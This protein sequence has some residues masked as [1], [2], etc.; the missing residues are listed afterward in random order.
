MSHQE[1]INAQA[2]SVIREYEKPYKLGRFTGIMPNDLKSKSIVV[3]ATESCAMVWSIVARQR[4]VKDFTG[5]I[6]ARIEP[7]EILITRCAVLPD[8]SLR[9]RASLN[10]GSW[11]HEIETRTAAE[12]I[13]CCIWQE[14]AWMRWYLHQR[15]FQFVGLQVTACSEYRA[16][17]CKGPGTF[18][19]AD[20][21]D[22]ASLTSLNMP[23]P[24]I[25]VAPLLAAIER[26]APQFAPH[27]SAYNKR[28]SWSAVAL[29][30]F[31][32]TLFDIEKP[33]EM[34][35]AWKLEHA[36]HLKYECLDTILRAAL[37]EVE[38]ILEA[39]GGQPFQR[40]RLMKL[41]HGQGELSRHADITDKEAGTA[42]GKIMRLH[43]PIV[44][45]PA[46]EF[47]SW[48]IFGVPRVNHFE[49][50]QAFYLDTRKAHKA[51]NGGPNDRIHL[52]VD[53]IANADR[54]ALISYST[55]G[56]D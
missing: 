16:L 50:G 25:D 48:D 34:S 11:L 8:E 36:E 3:K 32:G 18:R 9:H 56:G 55:K 13:W 38:P 22:Y 1:E 39:L 29:R 7:G 52:V 6:C 4:H 47:T 14:D 19:K 23:E 28:K 45:N 41:S 37:P 51:I 2:Y 42:D 46:V 5:E 15:G 17:Y 35:K 44:T 54:R 49:Q 40:I 33:A 53:C 12:T 10:V 43:V 27:Y 21:A 31:G 20:P 24:R 30:G 26:E